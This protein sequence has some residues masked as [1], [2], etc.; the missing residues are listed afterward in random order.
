[1]DFVQWFILAIA[2]LLFLFLAVVGFFC[3]FAIFRTKERKKPE[4]EH[5]ETEFERMYL[6]FSAS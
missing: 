6:T 2:I 3:K 1:M 4:K 5:I